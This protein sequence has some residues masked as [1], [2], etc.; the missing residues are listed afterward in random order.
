M[1][2]KLEG[3]IEFPEG[4]KVFKDLASAI[5]GNSRAVRGLSKALKETSPNFSATTSEIKKQ[6]S[7]V[8][9]ATKEHNKL[10][11]AKKASSDAEDKIKSPPKITS[12]SV[13]NP[14]EIIR[15]YRDSASAGNPMSM[16]FVRAA[17]TKIRQQTGLD[18]G[19]EKLM[20]PFA[21]SDGQKESK[22]GKLLHAF[23]H[24]LTPQGK[25]YP[26]TFARRYVGGSSK[27]FSG[28]AATRG[29]TAA[30]GS[31]GGASLAAVAP[32]AVAA[33]AVAALVVQ[34]Y[35]LSK[36]AQSANRDLEVSRHTFAQAGSYTYSAKGI[37]AVAGSDY[38]SLASSFGE[39]IRSGLA[40]GIAM[41]MGINPHGGYFGDL[42]YGKKLLKAIEAMSGANSFQEARR[43]AYGL[44]SPE[45]ANFYF[46]GNRSR[47]YLG[48][49]NLMA[50][51]MQMGAQAD[52][53]FQLSRAA[54]QW[55]RIKNAVGAPILKIGAHAMESIANSMKLI[56]PELFT[57]PLML[58]M[59][60]I[61]GNF[62]E[63]EERAKHTKAME[64]HTRAMNEHREIIGGNRANG[65]VPAGWRYKGFDEA[66]GPSGS[67][68]P[69]GVI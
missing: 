52:F 50:S 18:G 6:T 44:G 61:T 4:A 45:L 1:A 28:G 25:L 59:D 46:L 40:A 26:V 63:K 41:S 5:R 49:Q 47:K 38:G 2:I 12:A 29:A 32:F 54:S 33:V 10:A 14:W 8:R 17:M 69:L 67:K 42:D 56:R 20:P 48:E 16:R 35:A 37:G 23:A 11:K 13:N 24:A 15:L 36:A 19:I 39:G 34:I 62:K 65:A 22:I 31:G 57:E 60:L 27:L 53:Q 30:A 55:E 64:D 9:E 21:N 51:N 43:L 58:A 7:A 3:S 68:V 66:I